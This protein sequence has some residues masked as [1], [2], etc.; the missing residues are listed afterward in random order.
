MK[1]KCNDCE[2]VFPGSSYST[3]CPEC[4]SNSFIPFNNGNGGGWWRKIKNWILENKLITAVIAVI[5]LLI[6]IKQDCKDLN[7]NGICD[8]DETSTIYSLSFPEDPSGNFCIVKLKDEKGKEIPFGQ[9]YNFLDLRATITNNNDDYTVI[10]QDNKIEYCTDG[11]LSIQYVRNS[12]RLDVFNQSGL[13]TFEV[14]PSKNNIGKCY[15]VGKIIDVSTATYD[16]KNKIVINIT[17]EDILVSVNGKG[18][19]YKSQVKFDFPSKKDF[20]VW[21]YP[22]GYPNMKTEYAG[23]LPDLSVANISAISETDKSQYRLKV[24]SLLTK[25]LEESNKPNKSIPKLDDLIEDFEDEAVFTNY[26]VIF[27]GK[28]HKNSDEWTN[29]FYKDTKGSLSLVKPIKISDCEPLRIQQIN[30]E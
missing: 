5:L 2:E 15:K 28:K 29:E 25:V 30:I 1:Y 8:E 7:N 3:E 17:G 20:S 10:L 13:K 11:D 12:D 6:I 23:K 26:T 22:K 9:A 14:N 4:E 21:Y 24:T 27:K 18:G 19:D 16:C